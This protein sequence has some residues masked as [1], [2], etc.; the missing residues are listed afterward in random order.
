MKKI[1]INLACTC[2]LFLFSCPF[3]KAIEDYKTQ[4]IDVLHY[5]FQLKLNDQNNEIVGIS[6]VKLEILKDDLHSFYLDFV[7]NKN[8]DQRDGMHID[9][10]RLNGKTIRFEHKNDRIHIDLNR[11]SN[12]GSILNYSIYYHGYPSDG[13]IISENK[14]QER[15]FFGDNWPNRARQ[16]LPTVDHPSDKASCEFIVTAPA[17]YQVV[18]NGYLK[19]E[20]YVSDS[21]KRT[22]WVEDIPIST[23]LMVFG[24]A[25]FAVQEFYSNSGISI[26]SW[27]Y[28]QDTYPLFENLAQTTG[29]LKFYEDHFG[30]YPYEKLANVQSKTRYG[31]MENAG[32]IFYG[33][34]RIYDK[35]KCEDLL[36]H[37]IAHQWFGN[38]VSECDWKHIWISEG[39]ATYADH[40]YLEHKYGRADFV[41]KM[42]DDK[43][44]IFTFHNKYPNSTVVDGSVSDLLQ[45]LNKNTYEKGAWVLHMLRHRIGEDVFFDLLQR[46]YQRF[47][48]KNACTEDFI[49]MVEEITSTNYQWFFDQWLYRP[50]LPVLKG[51]WSFDKESKKL[52]IVLNQVQ[53]EDFCFKLP[54][55]IAIFSNADEKAII[56]TIFL[57]EKVEHYSFDLDQ[58]PLNVLLDPDTW[59]LM[60][61]DFRQK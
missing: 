18:S 33:E 42:K 19:E 13:L 31:G 23:K 8:P 28:P 12:K 2:L 10:I 47:Q 49:N 45:L 5:Q 4:K 53:K 46:Y 16:W 38:S 40:L 21:V 44:A 24:A 54:I 34:K 60:K 9:S 58:E 48:N 3:A 17:H 1:I 6:K 52:N 35:Q 57:D 50:E 36:A 32:C 15:T 22:Q 20:T 39:F 11:H 41:A 25:R 43:H 37:E 55:D 61:A 56:K 26:Q 7:S 27:V 51:E 14:Y 59:V 29:I 30:D